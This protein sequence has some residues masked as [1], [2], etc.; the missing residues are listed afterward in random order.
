M[1]SKWASPEERIHYLPN[2]LPFPQL[3][4]SGVIP[5]GLSAPKFSPIHSTNV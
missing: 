2:T 4:A 3:T 1:F 5:R